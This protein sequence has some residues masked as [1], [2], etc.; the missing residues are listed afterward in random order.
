MFDK[1]RTQSYLQQLPQ[2]LSW[3]RLI[4]QAHEHVGL[5]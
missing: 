1:H 3:H 5:W 4:Q 2:K